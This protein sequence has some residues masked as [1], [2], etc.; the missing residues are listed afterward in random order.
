MPGPGA[1]EVSI[2]LP[3]K[4]SRL[5]N[6]SS[7]PEFKD[8]TKR[9]IRVNI[10][11]GSVYLANQEGNLNSFMNS[12]KLHKTL[13]PAFFVLKYDLNLKD[14]SGYRAHF[15]RSSSRKFIRNKSSI[16]KS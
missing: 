16:S 8:N 3:K 13:S 5:Y 2:S 15:S 10:K 12:N 6:S 14:K 7:I 1:Y 11:K 9:N 4:K